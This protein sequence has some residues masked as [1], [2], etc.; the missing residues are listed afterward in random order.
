MIKTVVFK[1]KE[2]KNGDFRIIE[3]FRTQIFKHLEVHPLSFT[4][5]EKSINYLR[6][7][8]LR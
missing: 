4:K 1:K 6:N 3:R 2:E 5:C 7:Y 8:Y